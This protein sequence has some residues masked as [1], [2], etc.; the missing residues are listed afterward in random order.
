MDNYVV[1]IGGLNLDIAGLSG[2]VYREKDSNIGGIEMTVGGVG[3]N[4]AQNLTKLDVPTYL[5]TVYGDDYFGKF[6]SE[7]CKKHDIRLDYAECILNTK[8][9]TYLYVTDEKGD[10]VTAVN[11]MKIT[12]YI[13]PEFLERRINFINRASICVID[14]NIP[15]ESIEWLANNCTVPIFA[16]PVSIA[17][18]N[19]FEN[20]LDKIDTFKPNELEASVLSG[21]KI[22]DTESAK[23]A[24]RVLHQ[25]GVK[26][27]F[28]SLGSKGILCSREGEVDCIPILDSH[29]V[30]VNGAGDC[31]MA[32]ITWARF[33]YGNTIPLK[34][35]GMLTQA[36]ASLTVEV[37]ESVSPNLNIKNII[38][39]AK[40]FY[41]EV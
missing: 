39:R 30:S 38:E 34:R 13:T 2:D 40:K 32:T 12:E 31:S 24:A 1:V 10:M 28:I 16:D 29:I 7:E 11:D 22:V 17:K 33:Q 23:E 19:R 21:V 26:N 25:K 9:S 37:A 35:V 6:L 27:V 5:V 36:A 14:G 20:I 41:E 15:K 8:S 4:I 3:Q 18:V